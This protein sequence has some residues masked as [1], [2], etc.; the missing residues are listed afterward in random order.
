M[1]DYLKQINPQRTNSVIEEI[2]QE[3]SLLKTPI[4]QIDA[5]NLIIQLI[6]ASRVSQVLEIGTA[7][8]YSAIMIATYTDA[9]V[10]SIERDEDSYLRAVN[11]VK[12]ANLDSK[13]KLVLGDAIEYQISEDFQCDLLFIDAS[14]SSYMKF[15]EKYEM[16]VSSSGIIV[17]DNLLFRGLVENPELIDSKNKKQLVKKIRNFNEYIM[18]NPNYDS[19]IYNL[20]DGLSV[21]IKK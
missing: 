12:K 9:S 15:F 16:Y 7:I 18:N 14:K 6:Q 20:G 8:G 19:Y 1:S 3:A 13:I 2:L 11:N 4:I 5:I 10:L 17:S 21:S